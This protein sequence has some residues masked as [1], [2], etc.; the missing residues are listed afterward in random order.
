[1]KINSDCAD[2]LREFNAVAA[3]YLV[4][5]ANA[6]GY[7]GRPRATA[8]FDIWVDRTRANAERVYRALGTFG[9]PLHDLTVEDLT[10]DDLM[11]QMGV[12]PYRID[13]ITGIDGVQFDDAWQRRSEDR[14][15]GEPI[16]VIGRDDLIAN[17]RACGRPKDLAD[18]ELLTSDY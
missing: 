3:R 15:E 10:S 13:I 1:M 18:L 8:D 7:H 2:L 17:K 14:I 4:V 11:F 6:V 16:H 12:A 9:A 5:G